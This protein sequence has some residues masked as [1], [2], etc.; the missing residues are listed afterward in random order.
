MIE[1]RRPEIVVIDKKERVCIIVDIA[2]P[3]D[4][5]VEEKERE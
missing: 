2:V 3:A 4:R 1:V 5:R